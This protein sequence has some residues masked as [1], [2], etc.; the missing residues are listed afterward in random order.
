MK[1]IFMALMLMLISMPITGETAN[2]GF[3]NLSEVTGYSDIT[4]PSVELEVQNYDNLANFD[5]DGVSYQ[6]VPM[7]RE[8]F[9]LLPYLALI[10]TI[11]YRSVNA[12]KPI[13]FYQVYFVPNRYCNCRFRQA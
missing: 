3:G 7:I 5:A 12:Y 2:L 4:A 1:F 13:N 10:S 8:N 9:E 6:D 11:S